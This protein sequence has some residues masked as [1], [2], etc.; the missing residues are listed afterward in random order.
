MKIVPKIMAVFVLLEFCMFVSVRI[1]VSAATEQKMEVIGE[2]QIKWGAEPIAS[3]KSSEVQSKDG[4]LQCNSQSLLLSKPK[5]MSSAWIRM[6]LPEV[7]SDLHGVYLGKVYAQ[8]LIIFIGDRK[9]YE[10]A[11]NV[12]YDVN[13]ILLPLDREDSGKTLIIMAESEMGRIGLG[14]EVLVGEFSSLMALFVKGDQWSVTFGSTLLFI[15]LTML[16]V[17]IFL[18]KPQFSTWILLS[19]INLTIG[20]LLIT[21]S[22]YLFT[23]YKQHA[24]IYPV[25]FDL[26]LY[27]FL[28]A[29]YFF[30]EKIFGPGYFSL[31][32]RLGRL[33]AVYSSFCILFLIF[34]YASN[35]SF[36]NAYFFATVTILGFFMLLESIV[37]VSFSLIYAIKGNKD[38]LLF[39]GGFGLF[40]VAG[41][42][43]LVKFYMSDQASELFYWKLGALAF[44]VC[45]V[46]L[47]GKRLASYHDQLIN[48]SKK[49]ELH[50][51]QLQ[52]SE[53]MEII[54]ELAASVAHEVRN[55][56]QV[57]RGFLQLLI[58]KGNEDDKGKKY[59]ALAVEE[60]D[61]AANIITDFL[62]FAKPQIEDVTVLD[63]GAELHQIEGMILP[64]VRLQGGQI[65][66]DIPPAL[67]IHGNSSKFKQAL[68]NVIK[69][70][71]EALQI[72]GEI[73]IW[74]YEEAGQIIM[75]IKDNGEGME[76][77]A[78]GKLGEPYFSMKTKG[79]GLG[80]MVT[81]RIIEVME[82]TIEFKSEKGVGTEAILRFPAVSES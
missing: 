50:N 76:P 26:S 52:H 7:D 72:E 31:I 79:T 56:L 68:I 67:Y 28:P 63:I 15:S 32:K 44:V 21:Y 9:V 51:N 65:Q 55:P 18:K 74:A 35:F 29:L 66:M 70:S 20:V 54:S 14:K 30:F 25:F 62:T 59:M 57:T 11:R 75:H 8:N 46:V 47:L 69:N 73:H 5:G 58:E 6:E 60:L 1:P 48:Y 23:F 4:W 33:Q 78:L 53:K 36:N 64:M 80:L 81:F 12:L 45:L 71:I 40:A 3:M 13:R 77:V 19:I 37:L 22:P 41:T 39:S 38:A 10:S 27:I 42:V 24:G 17:S 2:W 16:M 34:N 61:R 49:L 43:D 82:G